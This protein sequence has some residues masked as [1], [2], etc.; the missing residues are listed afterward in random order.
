M[1]GAKGFG[2]ERDNN[3]ERQLIPFGGRPLK[4]PHFGGVKIGKECD[5]GSL[6]TIAA[7]AIEPTY[8]KD[9][10]MTDDHVHIAHNRKVG[11]GVAIAACAEISGSVTILDECW[12]GPNVS[13]M[14]KVT[15][16][17]EATIIIGSVVLKS[18]TDKKYLQETL[19]ERLRK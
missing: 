13:I 18:I 6:N 9:N 11:S 15:I 7:G 4:M 2:L 17:K 16:G 5:I 14:Q 1:I 10:V 19:Q 8:L 3:K 12:I